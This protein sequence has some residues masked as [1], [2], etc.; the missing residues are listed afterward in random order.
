MRSR[1]SGSHMI[2]SVW[3][4]EVSGRGARGGRLWDEAKKADAE[5]SA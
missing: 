1:T 2:G 5:S 3:E 4:P